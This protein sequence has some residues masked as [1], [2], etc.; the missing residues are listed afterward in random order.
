MEGFDL[1]HVAGD[2]R[3]IWLVLRHEATCILELAE[4]RSGRSAAAPDGGDEHLAQDALG[5]GRRIEKIPSRAL[6]MS[7]GLGLGLG[8]SLGVGVA[9]P[10]GPVG[11]E[12]VGCPAHLVVHTGLG[13]DGDPLREPVV[14]VIGAARKHSHGQALLG[15]GKGDES[16]PLTRGAGR[17]SRRS[18][19]SGRGKGE[20]VSS[21]GRGRVSE[22]RY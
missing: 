19:V 20:D 8:L 5:S 18:H 21:G 10:G 22:H 7:V 1:S 16:G 2:Y 14:H 9:G 4:E 13:A 3:R 15:V 12:S 17:D 6:N 11:E